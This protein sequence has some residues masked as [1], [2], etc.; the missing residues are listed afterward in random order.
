MGPEYR[1]T[2]T[3]EPRRPGL[4]VTVGLAQLRGSGDVV[5]LGPLRQV[6]EHASLEFQ[7]LVRV[8]AERVGCAAE[9]R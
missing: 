5:V 8:P 1:E 3:V 7:I 6:A 4:P 9:Q 2:F